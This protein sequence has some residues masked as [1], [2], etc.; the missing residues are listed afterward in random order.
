L[1]RFGRRTLGLCSRR[2]IYEGISRKAKKIANQ[3]KAI[4]QSLCLTGFVNIE[5]KTGFSSVCA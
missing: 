4:G 1:N 5:R 2:A 3:F